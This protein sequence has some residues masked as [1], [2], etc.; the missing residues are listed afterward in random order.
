MR[1]TRSDRPK[2]DG[3]RKAFEQ[4]VTNKPAELNKLCADATAT[5]ISY[6]QP[7]LWR[8]P[9]SPTKIVH[10]AGLDD[11]PRRFSPVAGRMTLS[12]RLTDGEAPA[13]DDALAS[14]SPA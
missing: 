9:R 10:L 6:H 12:T 14:R 8:Y 7:L 13:E 5:R 2:L 1:Q 11:D 3:D 4:A